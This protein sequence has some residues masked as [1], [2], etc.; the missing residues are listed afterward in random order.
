MSTTRLVVA[1]YIALGVTARRGPTTSYDLKRYVAESIGYFWQIPHAQLY[2][3]PQRLEDLGLLRSRSEEG[4]RRR[5]F[6]EITD[7][8]REAFEAWLADPST[9]APE[10]RDTGLLKLHFGALGTPDDVRALG[11]HQREVREERLQRFLEFEAQYDGRPG[12][13]HQ[14]LTLRLGQA[15][16]R[17]FAAFWQQVADSAEDL[18]EGRVGSIEL[19]FLADEGE[20]G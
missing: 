2:A 17:M 9:D 7:A 10:L 11:E 15:Y 12:Q 16:E 20:R 4:G 3:E 18:A 13:E 8:G 6:F 5:R 19:R 1:S 14:L